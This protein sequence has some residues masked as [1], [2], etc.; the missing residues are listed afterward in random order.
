MILYE[1]RH[2]CP[3]TERFVADFRWFEAKGRFSTEQSAG[4]AQEVVGKFIGDVVGVVAN[5]DSAK[6]SID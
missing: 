6:V 5:I 1:K 2:G 3:G 4:V